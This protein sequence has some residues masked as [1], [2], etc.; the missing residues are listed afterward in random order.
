MGGD[1]GGGTTDVHRRRVRRRQ[2][3][4]QNHNKKSARMGR[5]VDVGSN[6]ECIE[7]VFRRAR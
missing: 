3:L 6:G 1:W 2:I 4:R 5:L 7:G